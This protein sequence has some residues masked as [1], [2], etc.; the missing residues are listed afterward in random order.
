[1]LRY[2]NQPKITLRFLL[3]STKNLTLMVSLPPSFQQRQPGKLK[4]NASNSEVEKYLKDEADVAVQQ[5]YT[6]LN[7]R[8]DQFGVTQPNIQLQKSTNRILIELPG[9]KEPERVRKLLSGI[10]QAGVLPD[11]R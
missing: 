3:M 7:T 8:I 1:M 2:P 10:G 6:V 11:F 5:S 9:V 4:F